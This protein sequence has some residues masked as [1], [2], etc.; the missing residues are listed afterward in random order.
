MMIGDIIE[1][2]REQS[3]QRAFEIGKSDDEDGYSMQLSI[4]EVHYHGGELDEVCCRIPLVE[5]EALQDNNA[6]LERIQTAIA[7]AV[8]SRADSVNRQHF[9][10]IIDHRQY[11]RMAAIN[12]SIFEL[13]T[14]RNAGIRNIERLD[15]EIQAYRD[16]KR[17]LYDA[18]SAEID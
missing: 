10:I 9:H 11:G 1:A 7:S 15:T 18:I 8:P 6:V 2:M 5:G 14:L 12:A 13:E 4:L 3:N 16:E 17:R